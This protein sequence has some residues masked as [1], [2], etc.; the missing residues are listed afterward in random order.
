MCKASILKEK[1]GRTDNFNVS[2]INAKEKEH[3]LKSSAV[4]PSTVLIHN[5]KK[6]V[7]LQYLIEKT[8]KP[9]NKESKDFFLF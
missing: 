3:E 4:N 7:E 6:V 9:V 5:L 2:A 1:K 8:K